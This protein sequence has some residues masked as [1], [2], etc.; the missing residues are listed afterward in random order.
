MS[1]LD[2][3]GGKRGPGTRRGVQ[4]VAKKA[5]EESS[6]VD[7][8]KYGIS[9]DRPKKGS[10]ESRLTG[11]AGI[12]NAEGIKAP[13]TPQQSSVVYQGRMKIEGVTA[14]AVRHED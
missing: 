3:T 1:K 7:A 2:K 5:G 8:G 12:G 9:E 6:D 11:L 14:I 10:N 4:G 13:H